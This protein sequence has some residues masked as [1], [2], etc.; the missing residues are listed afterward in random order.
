MDLPVDADPD[1]ADVAFLEARIIEHTGRTSGHGDEQ[2]LA[3]IVRAGDTDGGEIIGGAYGWTWGG[4][5][6][7]QHLW[8][9][10]GHRAGSSTAP[11]LASRLVDAVEAEMTRR[12]CGQIT[13]FTHAGNDGRSGERWTR[14]GY[15]LVG[16]VDDYP[17]GDAALWYR[18]RL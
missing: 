11:S 14:R 3:I 18:K 12:G 9:H 15:E 10:P 16:R 17:V 5:G 4:C 1:P 13:L 8:V 7:L 6:E 2:Q